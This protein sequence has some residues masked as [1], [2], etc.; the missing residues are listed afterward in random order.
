MLKSVSK[1]VVLKSKRGTSEKHE[2][3]F[4]VKERFAEWDR[5]QTKKGEMLHSSINPILTSQA[6]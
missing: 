6:N 1:K 3:E 4:H 2:E 5:Q